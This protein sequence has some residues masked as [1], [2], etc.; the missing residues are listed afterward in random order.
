MAG[1]APQVNSPTKM[2]AKAA[3]RL[4][5]TCMSITDLGGGYEGLQNDKEFCEALDGEIFKCEM[6]GWW[7]ENYEASQKYAEMSQLICEDCTEYDDD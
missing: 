2:A 1:E 7:C 6:Y 4:L 5:G 3:E